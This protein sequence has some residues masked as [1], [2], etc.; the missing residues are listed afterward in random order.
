M[1]PRLKEVDSAFANEI[2]EAVLLSDPA[3]P[4]PCKIELEW[5]GFAGSLEGVAEDRFDQV[6]DAQRDL[7]VCADPVVEI[8]AKLR[9]KGR[10]SRG[11]G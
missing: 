6:E 3:G 4:T 9:A 7:P 2:D 5:L 1:V 11:L 8:V 10:S